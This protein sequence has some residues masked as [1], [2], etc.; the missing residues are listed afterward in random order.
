MRHRR[1]V[2][3]AVGPLAVKQRR[4]HLGAGRAHQQ[5]IA[6]RGRLQ[7]ALAGHD[8]TGA[9]PVVDHEW[10]AQYQCQ[11]LRHHARE[12][13]GAAPGRKAHHDTDRVVRVVLLGPRRQWGDGT[14]HNG[15]GVMQE[16]TAV[17]SHWLVLFAEHDL[18]AALGL[19]MVHGRT[20]AGPQRVHRVGGGQVGRDAD[21]DGKARRSSVWTAAANCTGTRS[22]AWCPLLSLMD[23]KWPTSISCTSCKRQAVC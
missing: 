7:H 4:Y 13:V 3:R 8:A 5:R 23:L 10:L 20:S 15:H 17:H 14:R 12:H 22:P 21:A 18:V 16:I 9:G 2:G 11:T 1:E 6:V 19:G